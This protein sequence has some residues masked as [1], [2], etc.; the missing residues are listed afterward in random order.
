MFDENHFLGLVIDEDSE[1][2]YTDER[3]DR[4]VEQIKRELTGVDGM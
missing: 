1:P 4:W 3:V 2:E